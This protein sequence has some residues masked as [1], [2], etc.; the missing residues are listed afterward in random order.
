MAVWRI[1]VVVWPFS[2]NAGREKDMA[3][4]GDEKR[5]FDVNADEF[6]DAVCASEILVMGIKANPHVWQCL[7]R[8]IK[9]MRE[10]RV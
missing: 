6:K 7:V 5:Y 8:G 3:M 4:V 2:T 1:D 10:G 9:W